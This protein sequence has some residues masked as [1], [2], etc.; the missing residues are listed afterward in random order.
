MRE[1]PLHVITYNLVSIPTP[2]AVAGPHGQP[3]SKLLYETLGDQS[4][5]SKTSPIRI[6]RMYFIDTEALVFMFNRGSP[7]TALLFI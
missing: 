2:W 6:L 1:A 4:D 7:K 3:A 5:K